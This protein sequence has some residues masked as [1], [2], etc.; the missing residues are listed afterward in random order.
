MEEVKAGCFGD[1]RKERKWGGKNAKCFA[2]LL[3]Q[4]SMCHTNKDFCAYSYITWG[5]AKRKEEDKRKT[6]E[7]MK[8]L[9]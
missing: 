5:S 7:D 4:Y 2:F 6:P 8:E 3:L 9:H 1:G